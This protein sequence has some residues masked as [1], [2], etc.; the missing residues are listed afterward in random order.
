MLVLSFFGY[1]LN[2]YLLQYLV[3]DAGAI[4]IKS[5]PQI[6]PRKLKTTILTESKMKAHE[7]NSRGGYS[8]GYPKNFPTKTWR[9]LAV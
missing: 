4:I 7:M 5:R 2:V 1:I 8:G 6:P 9:G 3:T